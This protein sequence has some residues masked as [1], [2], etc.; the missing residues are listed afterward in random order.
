MSKHVPG[1]TH[2]TSAAGHE[3]PDAE[4]LAALRAWHAGLSARAAIEQYLP[5]ALTDGASAR[6]VLGGIRR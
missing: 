5:Q 6:G 4:A 1:K 2:E 3:L